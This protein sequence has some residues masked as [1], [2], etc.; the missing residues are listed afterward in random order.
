MKSKTF[1]QVVDGASLRKVSGDD[2]N[3]VSGALTLK[4]GGDA[5]LNG[6]NV[7]LKGSTNVESVAGALNAIV[8]GMVHVQPPGFMGKQLMPK[9]VKVNS[10]DIGKRETPK[11][12]KPNRTADPDTPRQG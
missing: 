7:A 9:S 1:T 2:Y 4:A 6:M 11:I 8:G 12:A 3:D 10:T 5:T